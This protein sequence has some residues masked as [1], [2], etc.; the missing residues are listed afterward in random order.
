M[1][2]E[3]KEELNIDIEIIKW[4]KHTDHFVDGDHWVAFNCVAKIIN[5]NPEN[6]EPLKHSEIKWFSLDK[7]PKNLAA[8]TKDAA[9]EYLKS[10]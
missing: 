4:L 8:P 3:V 6:M 9:E 1:K 5:G 7:M 10:L 2:R